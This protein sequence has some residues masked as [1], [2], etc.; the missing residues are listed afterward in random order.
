M[1]GSG[2][3]IRSVVAAVLIALLGARAL[4]F[5][6]ADARR[7]VDLNGEWRVQKASNVETG[8]ATE[9]WGKMKVPGRAPGEASVWVE[10]DLETPK[11][12]G[13]ARWILR[14]EMIEQAATVFIDG[15]QVG[16]FTPPG[17]GLDIT[18]AIKPGTKQVLRLFMTRDGKPHVK[19]V[20]EYAGSSELGIMG[21]LRLDAVAPRVAVVDAFLMP[22]VREKALKANVDF[23]CAAAMTDMTL[24]ATVAGPDGKPVREFNTTLA[25]VPA[26]ESTQAVSFPW[27]DPVLW[28]LDRPYL[29][30]IT[31]SATAKDGAVLDTWGPETFGFREFWVDGR[32]MML[33]GHPCRFHLM[34]HWGVGDNNAA[35]FQGIGLNTVEIQ[36]R[37]RPW[38]S[39]WGQ[40]DEIDSLAGVLD[41]HGMALIAPLKSV[42]GMDGNEKDPRVEAYYAR[43][44]RMEI[45]R[46]KN[47]PSIFVWNLGMN[48]CLPEAHS[49]PPHIGQM[50]TP[51][52]EKVPVYSLLQRSAA[53]VQKI[54]P[55]RSVTSHADGN[56]TP[57]ATVNAYLNFIPM[58]EREEWLSDWGASG[59]KPFGAVEFGPPYFA[60][61]WHKG[62]PDPQYTEYSAMFLGDEAYRLEGEDYVSRVAEMTASNIN[63]HGGNTFMKA[64]G[65]GD[66]VNFAGTQTGFFPV[67]TEYVRRTNR[68]WRTSG[69]NAGTHPWMWNVGFG[70]H[71][72]GPMGCFFY[73]DLKGTEEELRARPVWANP[74]YDVF[75]ETQQGLLA[76]IGGSAERF[77]A[78]DHEFFPGETVQKQVI[79]LWDGGWKTEVSAEWEATVGGEKIAGG[80]SPLALAAGEIHKVPIAFTLPAAVQRGDGEIHLKVKQDGKD[81]STDV[82][83]F[84]VIPHPQAAARGAVLLWDPTGESAWVGQSGATVTAW[85]PGQGLKATDVLIIGRNA[86]T[87]AETLPFTADDV[88]GGAKVIVLEQ[89]RQTLTRFGF[90]AEE[91]YSRRLFV[92]QPHHPLLRGIEAAD[93]A[94][95]RGS[96]TLVPDTKP[97]DLNVVRPRC[98]HWGNY[99]IV[100]SV[101]IE[102]P[103]HG[104]FTPIVDGE[105]DMRYSPLLEWRCGAGSVL[106][107]QLDLTGRVGKDP[108]A[109]VMARNLIDYASTPT[110]NHPRKAVYIGGPR[111]KA[112][113]QRL[114]LD[115]DVNGSFAQ[116]PAGGVVLLGEIGKEDAA[117]A[118]GTLEKFVERGGVVMSLPKTREEISTLLPFAVQMERHKAHRIENAKSVVETIGD[119]LGPADMHWRDIGE[120]DLFAKTGAPAGAEILGD[121]FVLRYK[122]GK[123][124]W[125]LCQVDPRPFDDEVAGKISLLAEWPEPGYSQDGG[126]KA[127][128]PKP[129]LRL[130]RQRIDRF[131]AQVI[132]NLGVDSSPA[133]AR[134]MTKFMADPELHAP[135]AWQVTS[136]VQVSDKPVDP[137]PEWAVANPGK[138]PTVAWQDAPGGWSPQIPYRVDDFGCAYYARTVIQSDLDHEIEVP[139]RYKLSF[140]TT[141]TIWFNEQKL[142]TLNPNRWCPRL[143]TE[144]VVKLRPGRNVVLIKCGRTQAQVAI[145]LPPD[146]RLGDGAGILYRDPIRFGDDPYAWFPW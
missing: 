97:L 32:E 96:A 21:S 101:V 38:F 83:R 127:E 81:F 2:N 69:L 125:L 121:G 46:Y 112:F 5:P 116:L 65:G 74:Y 34:W 35:F 70:G 39:V 26:G 130:T 10:R 137:E 27:A 56:T 52:E 102:V 49:M 64:A 88:K 106:F 145:E 126:R 140:H 80:T 114:G 133:L 105:F 58:Q 36:P 115:V 104:N 61:F 108:V 93:L 110:T 98:M 19:G 60:N 63:G 146:A 50:L 94:D 124:M 66:E 51:G 28:E 25:S 13:N 128:L 1:A 138:T 23:S 3:G 16:I 6:P 15:T 136:K 53:I 139:V 95:W 48:I 84:Q 90:R 55:T 119:G 107:S 17:D 135:T 79:V 143:S 72:S 18:A 40:H 37:N 113:V 45:A 134:R 129:W 141:G 87:N 12:W 117:A 4:A 22:S 57:I 100:A 67:V 62:A 82:F 47:H 30:T 103:Q 24:R 75:R 122:Q 31:L 78:K 85:K 86:L 120:F 43:A 33:N 54:D 71:R 42:E 9:G 123:G 92:R 109:D 11:D 68:A 132:A 8:P 76:Y 91:T 7:S 131:Y 118:K 29:Y 111:G 20:F 73:A 41:R 144:S 77:T 14:S 44:C 59:K 89:Q 142:A 99:G